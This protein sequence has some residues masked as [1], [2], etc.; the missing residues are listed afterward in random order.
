MQ[1]AIATN[2]TDDN[3]EFTTRKIDGAVV[4][5]SWAAHPDINGFGCRV[6]YLPLG[7][8]CPF[9]FYSMD[10]A[11][12]V[13]QEI[14]SLRETWED[15]PHDEIKPRYAEKIKAICRLYSGQ[16]SFGPKGSNVPISGLSGT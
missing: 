5:G 16:E 8:A 12:A 4:Y 3:D 9:G 2:V 14:N 11:K 15:L 1:I 6:T 10:A 7:L 13:A